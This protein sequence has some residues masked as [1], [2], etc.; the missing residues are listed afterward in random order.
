M[1]QC[2]SSGDT[3]LKLVEAGRNKKDLRHA[4]D[5]AGGGARNTASCDPTHGLLW[6][7]SNFELIGGVMIPDPNGLTVPSA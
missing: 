1:N 7:E 4:K 3:I 2:A 6:S 5:R